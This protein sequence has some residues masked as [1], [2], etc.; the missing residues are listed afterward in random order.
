LAW[1]Y[2]VALLVEVET[3]TQ[4]LVVP[5]HFLVARLGHRLGLLQVHELLL[6]FR[7]N[8]HSVWFGRPAGIVNFELPS[9]TKRVVL[10]ETTV[11]PD[12]LHHSLELLD[13]R[14]EAI[15]FSIEV[16]LHKVHLLLVLQLEILDLGLKFADALRARRL[17]LSEVQL[18]LQVLVL[19]GLPD[20]A[21]VDIVSLLLHLLDVQF[22]LLFHAD[23][24]ANIRLQFD[25]HLLVAFSLLIEDAGLLRFLAVSLLLLQFHLGFK[26]ALSEAVTGHGGGG[27]LRH[28][29]VTD[30]LE[31]AVL[32]VLLVLAHALLQALLLFLDVRLPHLLLQVPVALEQLELFDAH[33]HQ[34]LHR[35]LDV[36]D[37][38]QG[39][40]VV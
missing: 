28:E 15:L 20:A 18:L 27:R 33:V 19:F 5:H 2:A 24:L 34:D 36:V 13:L 14:H 29:F 25:E 12:T 8:Y 9:S 37:Q 6:V 35:L 30:F 17:L 10:A 21:L 26:F 7:V 31:Q 38:V 1:I 11:L 32:G 39:I 40:Y 16:L 23:V 4:L 22:Q 3:A